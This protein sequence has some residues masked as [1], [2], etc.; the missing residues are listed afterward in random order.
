METISKLPDKK[1]F[2]IGTRE[3]IKDIETGKVKKVV[4]ASNCPDFLL[5]KISGKNIVIERFEEDE[6][7]LGT[8]LGKPFPIAMVG[9]E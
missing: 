4:V 3:I 7:Q 6:K 9:Y 2:T 1:E 5:A 8:R